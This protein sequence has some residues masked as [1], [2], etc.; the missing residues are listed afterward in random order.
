MLLADF[1]SPSA[2]NSFVGALFIAET[3]AFELSRLL[4]IQP[5]SRLHRM[6]RYLEELELF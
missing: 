5:R 4:G 1:S 6:N 2:F 3:I